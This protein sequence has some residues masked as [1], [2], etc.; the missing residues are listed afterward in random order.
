MVT[1]R[2][3]CAADHP[4]CGVYFRET[5]FLR[6]CRLEIDGRRPWL[7]EAAAVAPDRLEFTHVFPEI[8]TPSESGSDPEGRVDGH[9][10]PR[11]S[12]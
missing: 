6:V 1:G 12:S 10:F 11:C 4:L 9:G 2:G 3:D 7:C 8:I 5:R